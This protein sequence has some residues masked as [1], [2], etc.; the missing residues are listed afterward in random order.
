MVQ[1][2]VNNNLYTNNK[3][4][5]SLVIPKSAT[6]LIGCK[7]ESDSYRQ[8]YGLTPI[9]FIEKN[10]T[11]Y[12]AAEYFYRLTGEQKTPDGRSNFSGCEKVKTTF[13]LIEKDRESFT[14]IFASQIFATNIKNDN[15]LEN[16]F[17]SKYSSGCR[18][19][20]KTLS[21]TP[22]V[23]NIKILGDGKD[24]SESKCPINGGIITKYNPTKGKLVIFEIG[25]ACNFDKSQISGGGSGCGD[26]EVINSLKFL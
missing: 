25:H 3:F 10:D 19:G 21:D 26:I 24:L 6:S 22:D 5:F 15:E 7:K 9:T 18:L 12:L 4:G 23:Y 13:E 16:Y 1:K 11:I 8:E 2:D 17:K 20:E 14:S